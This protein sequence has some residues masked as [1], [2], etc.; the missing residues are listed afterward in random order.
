[1][2][3]EITSVTAGVSVPAVPNAHAKVTKTP[4]KLPVLKT[5]LS[6]SYTSE[7]LK[8]N[9]LT[10]TGTQ[11]HNKVAQSLS[12]KG[13]NYELSTIYD[14]EPSYRTNVT[15]TPTYKKYRTPF[16]ESTANDLAIS[17]GPDKNVILAH[18]KDVTPELLIH[19]F[20]DNI[21]KGKYKN[22]GL[23]PYDTQVFIVDTIKRPKRVFF[24]KKQLIK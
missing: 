4:Q 19:K 1:M 3:R 22:T 16:Y 18:D 14:A 6:K 24:L 7:N 8:A 21:Q 23:S 12:F 20:S 15:E 9:F 2:V 10:F 5:G 11:P 17:L 13:S